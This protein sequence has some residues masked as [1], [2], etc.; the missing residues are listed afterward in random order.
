MSAGVACLNCCRR[1]LEAVARV[2]FSVRVSCHYLSSLKQLNAFAASHDPITLTSVEVLRVGKILAAPISSSLQ[3]GLFSAQV[4]MLSSDHLLRYIWMLYAR[5]LVLQS[6]SPQLYLCTAPPISTMS[7][8][9]PS[10]GTKDNEMPRHGPLG[11]LFTHSSGGE[12]SAVRS[13]DGVQSKKTQH[14]PAV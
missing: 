8:R 10:P 12:L 13:D 5:S 2:L 3:R 1:R 7:C 6:A 4:F 11:S 9:W 14:T